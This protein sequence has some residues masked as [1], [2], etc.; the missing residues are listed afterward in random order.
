MHATEEL[1]KAVFAMGPVLNGIRIVE[2][3]Y[4]ATVT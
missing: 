4:Q 1:L 3:R 2:S